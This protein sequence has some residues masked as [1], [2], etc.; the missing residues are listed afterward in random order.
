MT[1]FQ[2]A[3]P[4]QNTAAPTF[5]MKRSHRVAAAS[6]ALL[7]GAQ[8]L[9]VGPLAGSAGAQTIQPA[10]ELPAS[11]PTG[12]TLA[13]TQLTPVTQYS[14]MIEQSGQAD[15]IRGILNNVPGQLAEY[16][17]GKDI[18][19]IYSSPTIKNYGSEQVK[20]P[21]GLFNLIT[22]TSE[23][24][25]D[26][27]PNATYVLATA[28]S[29]DH[30]EDP[31]EMQ[32]ED[33]QVREAVD[34]IAKDASGNTLADAYLADEG[35]GKVGLKDNVYFSK[36]FSGVSQITVDGIHQDL[37]Q[38]GQPNYKAELD[39]DYDP[40]SVPA[41]Y[42]LVKI[43]EKEVPPTTTTAPPPPPTTQPP[44]VEAPTVCAA[45]SHAE[46]DPK[47]TILDAH[48]KVVDLYRSHGNETDVETYFSHPLTG[49]VR[50]GYG[51]DGTLLG[52]E[53]PNLGLVQTVDDGAPQAEKT[54]GTIQDGKYQGWQWNATVQDNNTVTIVAQDPG[55]AGRSATFVIS[56]PQHDN[57]YDFDAKVDSVGIDCDQLLNEAKG[58][59]GHG[60][61]TGFERIGTSG[62]NLGVYTNA[63]LLRNDSPLHGKLKAR[64]ERIAA[65]QAAAQQAEADRL[66]AEQA[67]QQANTKTVKVATTT[68]TTKPA[69]LSSIAS[70]ADLEKFIDSVEAFANTPD[71]HSQNSGFSWLNGLWLLPGAAAFGFRNQIANL[72]RRNNKA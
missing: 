13:C 71:T 44:V 16:F 10:V 20:D 60:Q 40:G 46:G 28:G 2:P 32:N 38:P 9:G 54:S 30:C 70:A 59:M 66:A 34:F 35:A 3:S 67:A 22:D 1:T 45:S 47:I 23:T 21:D 4:A 5:G 39:N 14:T 11:M 17:P 48:G 69:D 72:F 31:A 29:E 26:L 62:D 50:M 8:A 51:P 55:D 43:S 56:M 12:A 58:W 68:S 53:L 61:K 24:F 7:S 6:L 18:Q 42:T 52:Y 33:R 36:P 65:E 27:D 49:E 15:A 63:E 41:G 37:I 64:A 57:G 19:A 25:T